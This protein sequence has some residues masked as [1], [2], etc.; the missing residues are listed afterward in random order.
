MT[1]FYSILR[2]YIY[3]LDTVLQLTC[4]PPILSRIYIFFFSIFIQTARQNCSE[5]IEIMFCLRLFIHIPHEKPH[6][7]PLDLYFN[8]DRTPEILS[9]WCCSYSAPGL[10][11]LFYENS[12]KRHGISA[13]SH[14]YGVF[15]WIFR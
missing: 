9:S 5:L 15:G 2:G 8:R 10:S 12:E 11:C 14:G 4:V 13:K 7:N 1:Q 3:R 6:S